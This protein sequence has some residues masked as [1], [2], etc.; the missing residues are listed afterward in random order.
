MN[1]KKL[2]LGA[3]TAAFLI[4]GCSAYTDASLPKDAKKLANGDIQEP[5]SSIQVKPTFLEKSGPK[6]QTAYAVAAENIEIL[7]SIPCYCGCREDGHKNNAECFINTVKEDGTVVWDD[8][9]TRC[10]TCMTIATEAA[11]LKKQNKSLQ[12]IRDII[13]TKY[14]TSFHEPTDTPMPHH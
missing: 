7:K 1:L 14:K 13:D 3:L 2:T 5:T 6:I 4:A 12:E 10:D 8:H 9:G 11:E